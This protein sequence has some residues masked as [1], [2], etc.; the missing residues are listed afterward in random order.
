MVYFNL[1]KKSNKRA[2]TH[3]PLHRRQLW[4]HSPLE[5]KQQNSTL[6]FPQYLTLLKSQQTNFK[7]ATLILTEYFDNPSTNPFGPAGHNDNFVSVTQCTAWHV[8]WSQPVTGDDFTDDTF[9]KNRHYLVDCVGRMP[10]TKL[11]ALFPSYT[12]YS[13]SLHEAKYII[14]FLPLS[15]TFLRK[16]SLPFSKFLKNHGVCC[17]LW[18]QVSGFVGLVV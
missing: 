13:I 17:R 2:D 14:A 5:K 15:F 4:L 6:L 11:L 3:P 16:I 8:H 10:Q 18:R 9:T 1:S 12:F 7:S